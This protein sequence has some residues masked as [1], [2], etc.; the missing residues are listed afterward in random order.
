MAQI[1]EATQSDRISNKE[2][3]GIIDLDTSDEELDNDNYQ[4]EKRKTAKGKKRKELRDAIERRR[5]KQGQKMQSTEQSEKSIIL[6]DDVDYLFPQDK[7]FMSTLGKLI[8]S[9]KCPLIAT[10]C[11]M[12]E[13]NSVFIRNLSRLSQKF[14][15]VE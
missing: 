6:F 10:C 2:D 9:A 14:P 7:G 13:K 3:I 5:L 15:R 1:G 12:F 8:Q 11:G 4:P